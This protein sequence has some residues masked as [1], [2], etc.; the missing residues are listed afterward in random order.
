M[1][2]YLSNR[3]YNVYAILARSRLRDLV[4]LYR[5]PS[6]LLSRIKAAL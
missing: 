2:E 3:C 1:R 5:Y 4:D 6:A